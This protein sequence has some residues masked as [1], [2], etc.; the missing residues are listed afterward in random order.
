MTQ[1]DGEVWVSFVDRPLTPQMHA[2]LKEEQRTVRLGTGCFPFLLAV[3]GLIYALIARQTF[4]E[5]LRLMLL[6][7]CGGAAVTGTLWFIW[8]RRLRAGLAAGIYRHYRGQ[9]TIRSEY[10]RN[11]TIWRIVAAG[12]TLTLKARPGEWDADWFVAGE[13]N[14]TLIYAPE[15]RHLFAIWDSGG[16]LVYRSDSYNLAADTVRHELPAA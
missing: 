2:A 6:F 1:D 13:A 3:F 4:G 7:W 10:R 5:L 8:E 11:R 16:R 12:T 14:G 9:F 15:A